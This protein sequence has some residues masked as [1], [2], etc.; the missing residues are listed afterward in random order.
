MTGYLV[1][2][3][4][5]PPGKGLEL[6]RAII[7]ERLAACANVIPAITS[8][9]YWQG[10]IEQ[11]AEELLVLKTE[12]TIWTNLVA[13]VKELHPYETPEIIC[14]DISAACPEYLKWLKTV[15]KEKH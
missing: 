12:Q 2:F 11:E 3:I 7:Q 4:T 6:A 9:Y 15:L 5:C 13:K 14:V 10:Q 1:G 8:V